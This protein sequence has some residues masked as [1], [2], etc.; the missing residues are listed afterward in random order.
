VQVQGSLKKKEKEWDRLQQQ[1]SKLMKDQ[2]KNSK[3]HVS[4]SKPIQRNSSQE[5]ATS[6]RDAELA[7]AYQTIRN[8]G[9]LILTKFLISS[10]SSNFTINFSARK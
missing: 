4:I 10:V 7:A 2:Q 1:L 9:V 3:C 5:K 6:I 8:I